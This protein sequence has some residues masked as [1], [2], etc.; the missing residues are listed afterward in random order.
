MTSA[1]VKQAMVTSPLLS[2]FARAVELWC[3]QM[4]LLMDWGQYRYSQPDGE[5]KLFSYISRSLTPTV[6]HYAQIEKETLAFIWA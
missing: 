1:E 3:Q 6:E 2:L 4:F 5:L